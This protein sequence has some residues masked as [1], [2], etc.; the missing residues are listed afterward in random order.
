MM[1]IITNGLTVDTITLFNS[2][3]TVIPI[4]HLIMFP[5]IQQTINVRVQI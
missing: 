1:I 3:T 2:S 5:N 4:L